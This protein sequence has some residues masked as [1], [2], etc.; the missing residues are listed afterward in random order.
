MKNFFRTTV[1]IISIVFLASCSSDDN[2]GGG[3]SFTLGGEAYQVNQATLQIF[4]NM[5]EGTSDASISLIG[6]K[7]AKT[8][9]VSFNV[10]YNTA[11]GIGGTYVSDEDSWEEIEGTYSSWLSSYTVVSGGGQDMI[12]SNQ[13]IGPVEIVSHGNNQYTLEFDVTY[14]DDVTASGNVKTTFTVQTMNI[15]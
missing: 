14:N 3:A 8:G 9:S 11:E 13:P 10:M 2:G 1:F 4:N 5:S 12:S 6:S 7:G 15:D